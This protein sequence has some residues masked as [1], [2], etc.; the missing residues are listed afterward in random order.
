MVIEAYI[1]IHDR[2]GLSDKTECHVFHKEE[3]GVSGSGESVS[4]MRHNIIHKYEYK[5][6]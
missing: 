4:S 6:L 1:A 5:M 3:D 2:T